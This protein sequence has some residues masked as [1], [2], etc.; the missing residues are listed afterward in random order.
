[1]QTKGGNGTCLVGGEGGEL[2]TSTCYLITSWRG[3]GGARKRGGW[4]VV[5]GWAGGQV[6]CHIHTPGAVKF[7]LHSEHISCV[8]G[9]GRGGGKGGA[10]E[11]GIDYILYGYS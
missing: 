3:G 5:G 10:R 2:G 4:R 1:M 7:S 11:R 8:R 6:S 9:G